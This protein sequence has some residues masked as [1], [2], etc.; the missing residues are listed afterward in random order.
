MGESLP[1]NVMC[2]RTNS[3]AIPAS[4]NSRTSA[5]RSSRL[6][7]SRSIE[8]TTTVSPSRT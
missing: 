6:R 2:S 7:A 3:T 4:V 1:V 5:R 8:W